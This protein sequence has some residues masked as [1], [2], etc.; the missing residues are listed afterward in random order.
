MISGMVWYYAFEKQLVACV[1]KTTG[2]WL[3]HS[4]HQPSGFEFL[5][6]FWMVSQFEWDSGPG[7][8]ARS[9]ICACYQMESRHLRS[10]YTYTHLT[11]PEDTFTRKKRKKNAGN[12]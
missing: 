8:L 6:K 3:V 1:R 11:P 9:D 5:L 10:T 7:Y 12:N 4:C 2:G